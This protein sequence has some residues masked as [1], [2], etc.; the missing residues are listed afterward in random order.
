M[1]INSPRA[2]WMARTGRSARIDLLS[3]ICAAALLFA[4]GCVA[5][6]A[7]RRAANT[8]PISE[9][10]A[11]STICEAV[12]RQIRAVRIGSGGSAFACELPSTDRTMAVQLLWHPING[13]AYAV[14]MPA[15]G[16]GNR[17]W[18]KWDN[19][20]S[21]WILADQGTLLNLAHLTRGMLPLVVALFFISTVLWST[22][23]V[24]RWFRGSSF[25]CA[26]L[27]LIAILL[28]ASVPITWHTGPVT[29]GAFSRNGEVLATLTLRGNDSVV[30]LWDVSTGA[31]LDKFDFP[32]QY[33]QSVALS[34]TGDLLTVTEANGGLMAIPVKSRGDVRNAHQV[35][36]DQ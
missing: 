35:K 16:S 18:Q 9:L 3:A 20:Q 19:S 27:C 31:G 25:V 32:N 33:C 30:C 7:Q 4:L 29:G 28:P 34:E 21:R 36:S 10:Q 22:R 11:T 12:T 6:P 2:R 24:G 1:D 5:I 15:D 13:H 8:I 17:P 26:G 14:D 23:R